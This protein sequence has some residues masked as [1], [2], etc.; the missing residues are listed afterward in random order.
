MKITVNL[1]NNGPAKAEGILTLTVKIGSDILTVGSKRFY[2]L[3]PGNHNYTF[4]FIVPENATALV[5]TAEA[6]AKD[7]VTG[8]YSVNHAPRPIITAKPQV[9]SSSTEDYSA[10]KSTD[11]T[12]KNAKSV[13]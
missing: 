13:L 8:D 4:D 9:D 12:L 7:I 10:E 2:G 11:K 5:F 1:T 6:C 3:A